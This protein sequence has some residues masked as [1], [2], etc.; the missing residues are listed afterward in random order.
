MLTYSALGQLRQLRPDEMAD[1]IVD[2][3]KQ[4]AKAGPSP[5]KCLGILV[6]RE[7]IR[8]NTRRFLIPISN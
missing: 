8:R 6:E 4:D 5:A 1:A 3:S 2:M 7:S